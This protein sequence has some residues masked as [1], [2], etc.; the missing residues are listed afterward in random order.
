MTANALTL[1]YAQPQ[2]LDN[3]EAKAAFRQLLLV[4]ILSGL[5][6]ASCFVTFTATIIAAVIHVLIFT[7]TILLAIRG[8]KSIFRMMSSDDDPSRTW[9][10]IFD[11]LALVGVAMIGAAP[12][13]YHVGMAYQVKNGEAFAAALGVAY[14]LMAATTARHVMLYRLL[15]TMCRG[16]NRRG[17]AGGLVALGWIKAVYEFLWLGSCGTAL[18][19]AAGRDMGLPREMGDS[20]VFFGFVGLVGVAGYAILWIWMM[21]VHAHLARLAR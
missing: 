4:S 8:G 7:A 5:C 17:F 14:L 6:V 3:A 2:T 19:L 18:L 15:A 10:T 9:R 16:T 12:V 11:I 21:V 13:V 20:A 1:E